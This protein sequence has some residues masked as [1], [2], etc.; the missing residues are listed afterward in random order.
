[1]T[2]LW[3]ISLTLHMESIAKIYHFLNVSYNYNFPICYLCGLQHTYTMSVGSQQHRDTISQINK[4]GR[5]QH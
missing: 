1:M 2:K 3:L 5:Q 4:T